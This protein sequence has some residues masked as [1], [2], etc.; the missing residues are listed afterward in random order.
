MPGGQQ[1][2]APA[3]GQ[4]TEALAA[5]SVD[6]DRPI[7]QAEAW[8]RP[9]ARALDLRVLDRALAGLDDS[10]FA[11]PLQGDEVFARAR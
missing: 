8:D 10:L 11:G 6:R 7:Q 2:S 1:V 5:T 4:P 3:T 9:A